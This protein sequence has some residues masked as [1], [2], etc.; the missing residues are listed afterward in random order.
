MMTST[1]PVYI[2]YVNEKTK[3]QF[4]L[5]LSV[6]KKPA[7]QNEYDFLQTILDQILDTIRDDESHPM[8]IAAQIIGDNLEDFDDKNHVPI[9]ENVTDIDL[10]RHLMIQN[11]LHQ[12]DMVDIFGNQG[13]VSKFLSGKRK[14]SK[15]QISKIVDRFN[16]SS[17]FFF[18]K[19]RPSSNLGEIST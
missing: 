12:D 11:N 14:L 4:H 10:I 7:T 6:F 5:P 2:D 1:H 3:H 15:L 16:I 18:R 8:A 9:G 13:N 19:N 17:D